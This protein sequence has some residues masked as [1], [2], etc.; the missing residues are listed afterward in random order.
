MFGGRGNIWSSE[1]LPRVDD[2][3]TPFHAG[4]AIDE[5]GTLICVNEGYILAL[6]PLLGDMNGDGCHNNYDIDA[7]LLA[8]AGPADPSDPTWEESYGAPI[9]VNLLGV[10]DCN[11]DGAFDNFDIQPFVDL[12]LSGP[13][14]CPTGEDPAPDISCESSFD[15]S[16]FYEEPTNADLISTSE[17]LTREQIILQLAPAYQYFG[18]PLP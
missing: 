10:G 8:L 7:F 2:L 6:R 3:A 5:D 1:G 18:I 13:L 14:Y 15:S 16:T 11:N 4:I 17:F 9:G 12:L